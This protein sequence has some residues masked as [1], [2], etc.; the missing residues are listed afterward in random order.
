MITKIIRCKNCSAEIEVSTWKKIV[1]CP[2]CDCKFPFE[3][4]DYQEIDWNSSMYTR[5][6]KWMDCPS[7]RSKNMYWGVSGRKWK[8]PDCGYSI[9]GKEKLFGVFWFCDKCEAFLNVQQNFTTKDKT[10]KCT[11]CGHVN[12]VT[13]NNII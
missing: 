8:C 11:E 1:R 2:Y 10:W 6:K 13:N 3:G 12:D 9:T 5:V 4:F 7:C